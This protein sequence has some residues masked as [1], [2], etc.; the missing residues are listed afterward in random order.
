MSQ[1]KSNKPLKTVA[2]INKVSKSFVDKKSS[3][4]KAVDNVSFDLHQG[5]VL[6]ILGPNG[7]GKTTLINMMLGRLSLSE[8]QMDLLGYIPGKIELK[9]LCGAMLQVSGVPDMSTVKEHI[10][11]FQCYY[12]NPMAYKKIIELAGL[13]DIQNNYCKNLSGGQKQ[14]LLFALSICGNPKI[15]FLDEPSVG[16]DIKSRKSLWNTINELKNNGTSLSLIHI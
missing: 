8:G 9:R 13:Q 7:A 6:S 5:E 4:T 16:M 3:N 2:C 14:R 11:L 10:Q 1:I 15:L 12:S